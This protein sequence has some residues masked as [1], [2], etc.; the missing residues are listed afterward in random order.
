MV[1][2]SVTQQSLVKL[3]WL[4]KVSHT[5]SIHHNC[6]SIWNRWDLHKLVFGVYLDFWDK[7][8]SACE[9]GRSLRPRPSPETAGPQTCG[10]THKHVF[11]VVAS[12]NHLESMYPELKHQRILKR[13]RYFN[14]CSN[15]HFLGKQERV[16]QVPPAEQWND[17][18]HGYL[19]WDTS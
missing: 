8:A 5:L 19:Q 17:S 18:K 4:T 10:V 15:W 9:I 1:C 14:C 6:F 7:S 13:L 3:Q 12:F 2:L 16:N 11:T